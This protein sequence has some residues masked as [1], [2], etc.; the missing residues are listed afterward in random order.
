LKKVVVDSTV[1][2][3]AIAYPTDSKLLETSR[4]K[5]VETARANGITLKQTFELEGSHDGTP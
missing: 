4:D 5:L 2:P 1:M 3:K